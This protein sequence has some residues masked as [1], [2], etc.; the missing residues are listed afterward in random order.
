MDRVQWLAPGPFPMQL[1]RILA[2][3]PTL[4]RDQL[5][6][7]H[8]RVAALLGVTHASAAQ[9]KTEDGPFHF[10]IAEVLR[11]HNVTGVPTFLLQRARWWSSCVSKLTWAEQWLA[12]AFATKDVMSLRRAALISVEALVLYATYNG[13]PL[14]TRL[15]YNNLAN[16]P[17]A[18]D[19]AYP[20][21]KSAG[22]LPVLLQQRK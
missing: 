1:E 18:V 16:V 13:A 17:A 22:L 12:E 10:A 11:Q 2:T 8:V 7:V 15:L 20:G 9:A 4:S 3:L 21:Y 5:T 6:Q 19:R 14:S